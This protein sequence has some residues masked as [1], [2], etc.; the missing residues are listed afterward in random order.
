MG[1]GAADDRSD[2][3]QHDR[4]ENRHVH[5]HHRFRNNSRDQPNNN[6]PD[7]VNQTLIALRRCFQKG[8]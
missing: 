6:V 3:A 5:M 7:E 4:P 8:G 1:N 2:D